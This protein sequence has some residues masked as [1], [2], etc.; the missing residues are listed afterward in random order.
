MIKQVN[1]V[2][3]SV[4]T[5]RFAIKTNRDIK[6]NLIKKFKYIIQIYSR[7]RTNITSDKN[8]IV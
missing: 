5:G 7:I 3:L 6:S 1:D 4:C 8:E 2:P